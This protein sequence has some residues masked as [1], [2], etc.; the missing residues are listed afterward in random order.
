MSAFTSI[1]TNGD[2]TGRFKLAL[3]QYTSSDI[4]G[5]IA[6]SQEKYLKKLLGNDLY[7]SFGA[8]LPI[9]SLDKYTDLLNGVTY[10]DPKKCDQLTGLR[11]SGLVASVDYDIEPDSNEPLSVD[12][13]GIKDML[14]LFTWREYMRNNGH[15]YNTIIGQQKSSARQS[16][17]L[18]DNYSASKLEGVWNEAV[19]YYRMCRKFICDNKIQERTST[20]ATNNGGGSWTFAITSTKYLVNGDTVTIGGVN[21]VVSSV[22]AD[23]SFNISGA[24][25]TFTAQTKITWDIYPGF[26][27]TQLAKTF[28]LGA[29]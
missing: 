5:Y 2:F 7:L 17:T 14:K 25:T 9:P 23:T 24:T 10:V 11:S 12:Y 1:L 28:L 18:A 15:D 4:D 6:Y 3:N 19:D 27:G 26:A 16:T 20:S 21:Y 8:Q 22:V 13:V 29:I